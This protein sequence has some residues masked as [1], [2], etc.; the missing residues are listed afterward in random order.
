[1]SMLHEWTDSR[2]HRIVNVIDD[3]LNHMHEDRG[4]KWEP[5]SVVLSDDHDELGI[6]SENL[7]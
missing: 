6:L 4:G 5:A 1:M 7:I 2:F 3:V